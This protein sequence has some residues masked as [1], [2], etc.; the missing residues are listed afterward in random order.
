MTPNILKFRDWIL[1]VDKELTQQTYDKVSASGADTCLCNDCKNYIGYRDKVFPEEIK[2]LFKDLGIDYKKEVEI[3][4]WE[5]LP[6]GLHHIGGWFHFKGHILNGKDFRVQL[7]EGGFTFELTKISD[8][9]S[10]GFANAND[11]TFFE[12]KNH[13][14]QIEFDTN[15]PWVI[16][17][18]LETK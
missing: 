11:L 4:S 8:N 18:K 6:N 9:F 14:V 15:I 17:N 7:P 5:K 10:I 3:T 12:E 13:L 2:N 1:E 16:E